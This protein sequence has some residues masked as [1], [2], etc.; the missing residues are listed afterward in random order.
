MQ[1]GIG[2]NFVDA[3]PTGRALLMVDG[4][5][6]FQ[7]EILDD[8]PVASL[9]MWDA[10]GIH[11]AHL[12]RGT[13]VFDEGQYSVIESPD[14]LLLTGRDGSMAEILYPRPDYVWLRRL[15]T[16]GPGGIRI[17]IDEDN[18]YDVELL[19]GDR[20][21]VRVRRSAFFQPKFMLELK[22]TG[23]GQLS[24]EGIVVSREQGG[25]LVEHCEFGERPSG[26]PGEPG[27]GTTGP[28]EGA[29]EPRT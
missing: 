17:R 10:G 15:N 23:E 1:V 4:A 29:E 2:N 8:G 28:S 9:N 6:V 11:V 7:A 18:G 26:A 27:K 24:H 13:W 20:S 14:R 22:E 16:F 21:L 12:K 3:G 5:R 25:L 19:E